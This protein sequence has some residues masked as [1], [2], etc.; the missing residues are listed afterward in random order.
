MVPFAFAITVVLVY[1][2]FTGITGTRLL[3]LAFRTRAL[4]EATLGFSYIVGGMLG[5]AALLIGGGIVDRAPTLGFWLNAVGLFCFSAGTLGIGLFCWRV[6]APSSARVR[7]FYFLLAT[8]LAVDFVHNIVFLGIPF[9]PTDTFWYWPGMLARTAICVWR[10]VAALDCHAR[11]RKRLALGLAD[12]VATNRVWL[13][14]VAGSI[15]GVSSLFVVAI[16]LMGVWAM[17]ARTT[18]AIATVLMAATDAT[19]SWLAF[20]PPKR[21]VEWVKARSPVEP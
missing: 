2:V 8:T 6:F 14:G 13:W 7:A 15:T 5:W 11:L 1:A 16:T 17:P 4:P 3:M 12:P 21:Y 10:P 9:P 18:A 19:L 20:V